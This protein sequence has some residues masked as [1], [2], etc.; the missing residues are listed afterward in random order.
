MSGLKIPAANPILSIVIAIPE[1][2]LVTISK[3]IV[4]K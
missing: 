4:G 2:D 3:S 1:K